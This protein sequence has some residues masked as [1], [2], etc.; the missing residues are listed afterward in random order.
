MAKKKI[1]IIDDEKDFCAMV[2]L[3]LERNDEYEVRVESVPGYALETAKY[4][5]PDLIFL[6][7]VMPDLD[8]LSVFNQLQEDRELQH[9]PVVFLTAIMSKE[10]VEHCKGIASEQIVLAKPIKLADLVECIKNNT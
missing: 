4:F 5:K 1:L 8:G 6:D 9:I 2:K 7:L 10:E 3:N